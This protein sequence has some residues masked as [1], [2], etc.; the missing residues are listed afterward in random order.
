MSEE[1][2]EVSVEAGP[3]APEAPVEPVMPETFHIFSDEPAA[4]PGEAAAEPKEERR[5]KAFLD[6]V[7]ADK[8]RRAQ[9][10]EFKRRE[11][12]LN[13][14]SSEYEQT[15][16]QLAMLREDPTSFLAS[17]GINPL[18]FQRML[19]EQALSPGGKHSMSHE[20]R[21]SQTQMEVAKLQA[22]LV[23]RDEVAK[24]VEE[25]RSQQTL[26]NRFVSDVDKYGVQH[27][28]QF[29][30]VK[31]QM[32]PRDVA[33]GMSVY[34]QETGEELSIEEAFERIEAG[35]RTHEEKFYNNPSVVEKFQRYHPQAAQR[36]VKGPQA[37]L[38]SK[39]AT[40]PTRKDP[41]DMS[42]E[43]IREMYKGKLF[44]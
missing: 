11:Q 37:T 30:L 35:L 26:V 31:E 5:S 33:E 15:T 2:T 16:E 38:S 17:Q 18:E 8:E 9:E 13:A 29:P 1:S 14:R 34:Y 36:S 20:D 12:E 10:I 6:K 39:W 25:T 23:N 27:G 24:E 4:P 3:P 43:E 21:L 44:T 22:E 7:R 19:A 28:E 32:T 42:F 41:N 40:Q